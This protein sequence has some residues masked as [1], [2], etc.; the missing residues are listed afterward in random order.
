[1]IRDSPCM[2][3][4]QRGN[5]FA[6]MRVW[7]G[8]LLQRSC[9]QPSMPE[10]HHDTGPP[11]PSAGHKPPYVSNVH[12]VCS[13]KPLVDQKSPTSNRRYSAVSSS[14]LWQFTRIKTPHNLV[15]LL[16]FVFINKIGRQYQTCSMSLLTYFWETCLELWNWNTVWSLWISSSIEH[17]QVVQ[18][19]EAYKLTVLSITNISAVLGYCTLEL[20]IQWCND[21][22]WCK[23]C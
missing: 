14:A 6:C 7:A 8:Q 22:E 2:H 4:M 23:Y 15:C 11:G 16:I 18:Y 9:W 20:W 21:A 1:M 13:A 10:W 17:I 5:R 19:F 12:Y 3:E